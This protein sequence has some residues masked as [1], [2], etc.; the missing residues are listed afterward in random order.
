M[1]MRLNRLTAAFLLVLG[2]LVSCP[3][4]AQADDAEQSYQ[5]ARGSYHQLR[6]S[7]KRQMYRDNWLK[8]VDDLQ[9][10][11]DLYPDSRRAPDALFLAGKALRGLYEVSRLTDDARLAVAA[12]DRLVDSYPGDNLVDD[13]LIQAGELLVTPLRDPEQAYR[14]YA[15]VVLDYPNADHFGD[16]QVQVKQL[17]AY[18]PKKLPAQAG[19]AGPADLA[20]VR[21]WTN[22]G[23]SRVVLDLSR[24]VRFSSHLL[25]AEPK[26]QAP[27]RLYVDIED[28]GTI[29][30]GK[31]SI[32]VGIGGL[33]QIRTGRPQPNLL[34]VV[35]DLDSVSDF[36]VFSLQDP[37]R[38]V[39]DVA[40]EKSLA[41]GEPV[42][43]VRSLPPAGDRISS[44]LDRTPA[45]QQLHVQIPD[46]SPGGKLQ[47]VV[48]D[49]GHGG[50]DPGAVGPSGVLEKDVT[51]AIAREVARRLRSELGCE[52]IMTRD[53]TCSSPSTPMPAP[54]A[55]PTESRPI[56]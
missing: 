34:R 39:I 50:K 43:E 48:V 54:I 38:I 12:F 13:A 27:P 9:A 52:V 20:D 1:D 41:T 22:A 3:A 15:R 4:P 11:R 18:A 55:A 7:S 31:E 21:F 14:R 6:N 44:I 30:P 29:P 36:K 23:Y 49:A 17:A 51:L 53:R 28:V 47:R 37:F 56:T 2:V 10:F 46:R 40:G 45:D 33:R 35:L 42:P 19:T 26:E 16:A 24:S 25:P 32:D 8:V 5:R